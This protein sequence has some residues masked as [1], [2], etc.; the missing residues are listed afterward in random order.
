MA[1]P[2]LKSGEQM[3]LVLGNGLPGAKTTT[4]LKTDAMEVIRLLRLRFV[5]EP[6][7]VLVIGH[8]QN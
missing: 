7:A 3:E 4:L 1:L 8:G 5:K 2:H 6:Q